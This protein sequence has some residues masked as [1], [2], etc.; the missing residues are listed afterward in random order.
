MTAK[1]TA[2]RESGRTPGPQRNRLQRHAE[3]HAARPW[4]WASVGRTA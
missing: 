3:G 1:K 4:V 2:A